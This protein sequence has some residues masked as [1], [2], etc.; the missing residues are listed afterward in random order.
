MRDGDGKTGGILMSS[1]TDRQPDTEH[2]IKHEPTAEIEIGSAI[3]LGI[4]GG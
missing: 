3:G 4:G 2:R 1:A